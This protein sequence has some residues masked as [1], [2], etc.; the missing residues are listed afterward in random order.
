MLYQR[1]QHLFRYWLDNAVYF[2]RHAMHWGGYTFGFY[3]CDP[4]LSP[5]ECPTGTTCQVLS[6][7]CLP[8]IYACY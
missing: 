2:G 4:N 3:I 6:S 1:K 7:S 5:S 8:G